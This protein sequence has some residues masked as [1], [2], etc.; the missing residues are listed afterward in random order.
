[1]IIRDATAADVDAI[2][3]IYNEMVAMPSVLW[4]DDPTDAGDR[5]AWMRSRQDAGYPVLV[6][7]DEDAR[8]GAGDGGPVLGYASFGDFRSFPGY[9]T[10]VEQ[11]IHVRSGSR[12]AG[13]G[14]LLLDVLT[15]RARSFAQAVIV[16]GVDADNDGSLRFHARNGFREVG[17]MPG[18]GRKRDRPVDLVLMQRDLEA[19]RPVDRPARVRGIDHVQLAMPAGGEAEATA[20]YEG[21]LGIPRVDK[22]P[23]LAG[24]GG[25]WFEDGPPLARTLRV[26]LGVDP[27][28]RPA[29]KA[30]PALV[31]DGLGA[32]V[33]RLRSAG[34]DVAAGEPPGQQFY[35]DDPFGN[36]IELVD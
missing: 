34:C 1:M 4:R 9:R 26:H 11:T 21:L 35:V 20:F 29:R 17:R 2:V 22:P 30:H 13:V 25:C 32:M 28:F 33:E 14:Q 18:V 16:A 36:R 5:H 27:R 24:R 12:G 6:A 3:E 31:V 15:E 23:H 7:V 8:G 19:V 10:T